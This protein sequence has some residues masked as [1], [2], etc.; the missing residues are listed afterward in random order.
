MSQAEIEMRFTETTR[1]GLKASSQRYYLDRF[2]QMARAV[3]LEDYSKRQLAGKK[4]KQ[5]ILDYISGISKPSVRTQLAAIKRV[6]LNG[7]GLPWPIDNK[8]DIGK[9]PKVGREST[10]S[11][12]PIKEWAKAL[13]MEKDSYLRLIWLFMAQFGWRPSHATGVRWSDVQNDER[14]HPSRIY[15]I[16]KGAEFKTYAPVAVPLWPDVAHALEEWRKLHTSPN[17]NGW[18][19]FH[20]E[21]RGKLDV[22]R[23][24]NT[25]FN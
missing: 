1:M 13:S 18:I 14:G 7:L 2:R 5:L 12:Q 4:G 8:T 25:F 15:A 24:I 11:D 23:R 20:R 22:N 3:S 17:G 19:L 9:L 10:P 16:G 6:W 21:L